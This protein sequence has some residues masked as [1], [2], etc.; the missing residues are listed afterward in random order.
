MSYYHRGLT[1]SIQRGFGYAAGF[2]LFSLVAGIVSG[3]TVGMWGWT[4]QLG[5]TARWFI[6]GVLIV[7]LVVAL[8]MLLSDI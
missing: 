8:L 5:P 2:A 4:G 7:G 3:I 6:R 1:N